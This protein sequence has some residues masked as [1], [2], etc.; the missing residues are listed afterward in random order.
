MPTGT[1]DSPEDTAGSSASATVRSVACWLLPVD[2][3]D[4][5]LRDL[6]A[7]IPPRVPLVVGASVQP[8]ALALDG[9]HRELVA[10]ELP[11]GGTLA[12]LANHAHRLWPSADLA[13]IFP[14][15][16]L[17][18]IWL[19]P[20]V[21]AL[22]SETTAATASALPHEE[23]ENANTDEG[24]A[25]AVAAASVQ[26]H[27]RLAGIFPTCVLARAS[28]LE[29]LG[30]LEQKLDSSYASVL[31][32][33][34]R[35][36]ERGLANLLA[37]DLLVAAPTSE[38]NAAQRET[39][40][41]RHP[42]LMAAVEEPPSPAVE[43]SLTL[44]SV[45]LE[46]LNVTV[47]ARALGPHV[48][49]TQEYLLGLIESLAAAGELRLRVLVPPDLSAG[50]GSRLRALAQTELLSYEQALSRPEPSHIVHRP[51][52]V[53]SA[54][55]LVLIRPLGERIVITH[56][57]LIAFH[58]P[59][60]FPSADHWNRY[61]R[62]TR[63]SLAGAD[64]VLFFSR[65]ALDDA[66]R[67]DLIDRVRCSV[68]YLGANL[69]GALEDLDRADAAAHSDPTASAPAAV[70]SLQ[71]TPFL[72]CIGADYQHKNR[73]FALAMLDELRKRHAWS[74]AIVLAG[75]HVEW[76]S[77]RELEQATRADRA[78][79]AELVV[80]QPAVS[81]N[82][83]SWLMR[84][85][86]AI[87]Y[88]TVH[89]G[90][91]LVPFEA[92]AADVP[93]LFA[94]QSSLSELLDDELATIVPWDAARS[95]DHAAPLL[96]QGAARQAHVEQLRKAAATL[97]WSDCAEGTI[98][99]YRSAM[100]APYRAS[101]Q[102][103]WQA[104]EREREIVRLDQGVSDLGARV[105]QLSDE[106]GDDAIALVG[107]H[108]L[109]SRSDQRVLLAVAARPTLRRV[110]LGGL[111]WGFRIMRAPGRRRR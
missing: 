85:A 106:L 33:A 64:H 37:D 89:E 62:T 41:S 61:V 50:T 111:R 57:D 15:A 108:A 39:L 71:R 86:A 11:P 22:A 45:A 38:L 35:A 99:A 17:P 1:H 5:A 98:A 32:F 67:E 94:A 18:E 4:A 52:Q 65:H 44:A 105:R 51:Q 79:P 25:S 73:P 34:L 28:A 30:P 87:V 81:T 6:L 91:G 78:I 8:D 66:A 82:E 63:Q 107:P 27:P 80:E 14:G 42:N 19:E 56:Q 12:H 58:N 76:G 60:Y 102:D 29:L 7:R 53:F 59:S 83:R 72:L 55:D 103:A 21:A 46:P 97:R 54:D 47:D 26:I 92:A 70:R 74:G 84:N 49:G 16:R 40:S 101:A 109:L 110:L 96:E 3:A 9:Q 36:R 24:D 95:A 43:R 88:P 13:L 20:L 48:G 75:P 23:A 90:F 93:C 100:A 104:L 10:V 31:D 69:N 2:A 77:S 68:V